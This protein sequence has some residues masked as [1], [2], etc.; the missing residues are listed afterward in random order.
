MPSIELQRALSVPA[1]PAQSAAAA[2]MHEIEQGIG[3]WADFSLYLNFGSLGLPDVGYAAI[4]VAVSDVSEVA[5][6][7]KEIRFKLRARRSPEVFPTFTGALGVDATGP[8]SSQ[9]WLAGEYSLPLSKFGLLLD[10]T[11]ARGKAEKSLSNMVTELADAI[12]ARVQ[13]RELANAR[14][15]LIFNT[16]D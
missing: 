6:P 7:R 13:N 1:V 15:R 3:E 14:Y 12:V 2:I 8:S 10:E 5:E 16:G 9:I 4:P 11:F